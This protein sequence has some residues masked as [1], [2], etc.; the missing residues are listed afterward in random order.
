MRLED[1]RTWVL[2]LGFGFG[3]S[4]MGSCCCHETSLYGTQLVNGPTAATF[5]R[6]DPAGDGGYAPN[7]LV[8]GTY[9]QLSHALS[10][11][12]IYLQA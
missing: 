2:G 10:S 11:S 4:S 6:Q 7:R 8:S 12:L 5:G 1:L 9:L 3:E